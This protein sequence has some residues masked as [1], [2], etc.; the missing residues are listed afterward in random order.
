[1]A[2]YQPRRQRHRRVVL[3]PV[4]GLV[5]LGACGLVVVAMASTVVGPRDVVVGA[6]LALLPVGPVVAAFLWVD[7]WEPEPPRLL[8]TAFLWGAGLAALVALV[9][10]DSAVLAADHLLGKA[11]GGVLSATV[12]A[13]FVEEA[14]KGAFVLG[15]LLLRRREFD[16]VVD[17]IVYAGITAAGFAFTENIIYF[18]RAFASAGPTHAGLIAVFVLRGVLAPFAHPLFTSMTGIGLGVAAT[19]RSHSV[20]ILAP[21]AGYLLAVC[22]HALWNASSL[23]RGG[24]L[25][26]YT[27]VMV[28]LFFSVVGLA[29]WQ[30]HR[31]QRVVTTQL[32]AIAAAGWIAPSEVGLLASLAGRRGW[33]NAVR[34]QAGPA[35]ARAVA[36]YQAAVTELAFLRSRMSR[37]TTGPDAVSWHGELVTELAR[38]RAAAL[39]APGALDAAWRRSR[40]R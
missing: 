19:T 4:V 29:V 40:A 17:G 23:L 12:S 31:E 35:A 30:R 24:F 15:V 21:L 13:P 26:V 20:R 32:P 25:I 3:A 8:L 6:V 18:G 10:N 9:I 22:L 7:R 37:G 27:L 38:S 5:L 14:A 33:R 11:S 39:A 16:G 34:R 1:M 2:A 36:G 28:P